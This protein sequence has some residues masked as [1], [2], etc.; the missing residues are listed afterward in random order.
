MPEYTDIFDLLEA[1]QEHKL[2][3]KECIIPLNSVTGTHVG[4]CTAD[5]DGPSI[6]WSISVVNLRESCEKYNSPKVQE[7]YQ[8]MRFFHTRKKLLPSV[9]NGSFDRVDPAPEPAKTKPTKTSSKQAKTET[10][11]TDQDES[12]DDFLDLMS[13]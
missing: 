5:G 12:V 13:S 3:G 11:D 2:R 1:V 8:N 9:R 7:I 4:Y 10:P 6:Q